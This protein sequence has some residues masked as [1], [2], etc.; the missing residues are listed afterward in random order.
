MLFR[1]FFLCHYCLVVR[2][3][4]L[5]LSSWEQPSSP[6]LHHP[7]SHPHTF[8]RNFH[9][10]TISPHFNPKP[11]AFF[12]L[13]NVKTKRKIRF[14]T[15]AAAPRPARSGAHTDHV[16]NNAVRLVPSLGCDCTVLFSIL[17]SFVFFY[18]PCRLSRSRHFFLSIL[19]DLLF[20][21]LYE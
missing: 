7:L 5:F 6:F 17:F 20:S 13:T 14:C 16:Y 4:P 15:A 10:P 9:T 12:F 19:S 1:I 8:S 2:P 3:A 11:R 18:P 21:L